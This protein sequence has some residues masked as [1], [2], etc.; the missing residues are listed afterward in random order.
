MLIKQWPASQWVQ[1]NCTTYPSK[2]NCT[3]IQF[4]SHL[5]WSLY[6][7]TNKNVHATPAHCMRSPET[8]TSPAVCSQADAVDRAGA[9]APWRFRSPPTQRM[10]R[11]Y[12][13]QKH[14]SFCK[15]V[16]NKF[17]LYIH[18]FW[19]TS[20][21]SYEQMLIECLFKVFWSFIMFSMLPQKHHLNIC[22]ML[23]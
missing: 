12:A 17:I 20:S 13:L 8:L 1:F 19:L 6:T 21:Q 4:W 3:S 11:S 2:S 15:R 14:T 22:R 16:K 23:L 7:S 10:S 18:S 5:I 9:A